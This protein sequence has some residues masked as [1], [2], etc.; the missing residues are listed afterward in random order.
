M[1]GVFI[2]VYW[3]SG[4]RLLDSMAINMKYTPR[5]IS[6]LASNEVFV[7]GA[8]TA[9]IHGAGAA[10]A[11]MR[12]GAQYG[13]Y[14][15]RGQT[16]GI[17]TKDSKIQTLSLD[18]IKT[19]VDEFLIFAIDNPDLVFLVTPIGT[20]LAGYE[21]EDIAPLFSRA[22]FIENIILPIQFTPHQKTKKGL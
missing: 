4:F 5:L 12:W 2:S 19:Y 13:K 9:G 10:K 20:G 14:G 3:G 16:Y 22:L 1:F 21:S 15:Y 6:G 18:K 7:Y 17:P 11:A 8:N